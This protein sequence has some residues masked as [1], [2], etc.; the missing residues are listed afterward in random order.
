MADSTLTIPCHWSKD[1][2]DEVLTTNKIVGAV[3]VFEVYG[4][5]AEGG[6]VG[7]GRSSDSVVSVSRDMAVDFRR[8]LKSRSLDFIYLLNAPFVMDGSFEQERELRD[9]LEWIL[10]YI[11]PDALMIASHELMKF[12]R[13]VDKKIPIHISTI[14]GVKSVKDLEI[15]LDI[16][17]I[18]VV[19]HHDVGKEWATLTKLVSFTDQIGVEIELMVTESCLFRCPHR[20]QHYEYLAKR[21]KDAPF[22]TVCNTVK[23]THPREFLLAGGVIRPEDMRMYEE[24]GIRRFKITGR[25]KPASWLPEVV[26]AYQARRYCGNL[27]RLLGI[28]PSMRAEEWLHIQNDALDGLT[29]PLIKAICHEDRVVYADDLMARLYKAGH[30]R[31]A[32]GSQYREQDGLFSLVNTRAGERVWSILK[33]ELGK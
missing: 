25:S 7:H 3:K 23:L 8:Y 30:F 20:N 28:D 6:P 21:T 12:V 13:C 15:F 1:V 18:R 17:P 26:M 33:K 5:M 14:A 24:L 11:Q 9:Y 27:I 4:V 10:V 22:H 16:S 19:P 2:I 32:D 29:E 31:V